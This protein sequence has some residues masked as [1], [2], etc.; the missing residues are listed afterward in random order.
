MIKFY[1]LAGYAYI[2]TSGKIKKETE[3]SLRWTILELN[4]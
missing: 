3:K 1:N 4:L 2:K